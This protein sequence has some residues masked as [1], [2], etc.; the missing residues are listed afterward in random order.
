M[1]SEYKMT[2]GQKFR[3]LVENSE[4]FLQCNDSNTRFEMSTALRV[5]TAGFLGVILCILIT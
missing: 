1:N 2:D 5:Y 3:W 4:E